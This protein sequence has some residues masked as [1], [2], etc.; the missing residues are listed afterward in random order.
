MA[1]VGVRLPNWQRGR[2]ASNEGLYVVSG[3]CT[4]NAAGETLVAGA[5]SLMVVPRFTEHGFTVDDPDTHRLKFYVPAGVELF[6]ALF[7]HPAE[8][9][10]L[11]PEDV[12]RPPAHLVDQ[13]S[14]DYGHIQGIG[15]RPGVDK[16]TPER[17]V[18]KPNPDAMVPP[19]V[20]SAA[21]SP[22]WWHDGQL[23]SVLAD[24]ARTDGGFSMFEIL[25]PRGAGAA[26]HVFVGSDA[27]YYILDGS[28]DMFIGDKLRSADK[29]DLVFVPKG[30]PHARR[31]TSETARAPYLST[32]APVYAG[33][34]RARAAGVRAGNRFHGAPN[35]GV[36][37]RRGRP[38]ARAAP[39]RRYRLQG[40]HHVRPVR[41]LAR[42]KEQL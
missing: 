33:R 19:Y 38:A 9:N 30:T 29:G 8:R 16:P 28:I 5:G 6:L 21:A 36:D 20:A 15:G 22:R 39:V 7:A 24:Q 13:L 42:F 2:R 17:M 35:V 34:F 14:R 4:F 3:R 1:V 11:P 37:R 23:W 40:R 26:P 25:G 10:E 12:P 27:F 18:T 41:L 31:V 32:P